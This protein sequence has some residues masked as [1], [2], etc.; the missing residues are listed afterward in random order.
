MERSAS[1]TTNMKPL[2]DDEAD[3]IKDAIRLARQSERAR[4]AQAIKTMA[5]L[6]IG[7]RERALFDAIAAICALRDKP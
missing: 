6:S 3:A 2:T 5:E 4:C 7:E 1:I